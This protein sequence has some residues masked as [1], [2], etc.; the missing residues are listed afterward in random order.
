MVKPHFIIGLTGSS[1][2]GK[3]TVADTL[4]EL[5]MY[6]IDC[7]KVAHSITS[8][9]KC[10][11][12]LTETFGNEILKENGK[13]NRKQLGEIVFSDPESLEKLNQITHPLI[14]Q[15]LMEMV[16][17]AN[18][19]YVVL[20]APTLFESGL[21]GNCDFIVSVL[22]DYSVRMN[23]IMDRDHLTKDEA[24]LRLDAQPDEF[25]YTR[26]SNI[27]I[28]NNHDLNALKVKATHLFNYVIELTVGNTEEK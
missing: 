7:D 4:K 20:D 6:R 12:Q 2:C 13:L 22:A 26:Q 3:S 28:Y 24:I 27:V 15:K 23:R 8:S 11:H 14:I 5:G 1:G 16:D 21:S 9:S 18:N 17:Q 25:F 10:L 19:P